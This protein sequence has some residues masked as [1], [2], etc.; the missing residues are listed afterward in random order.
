MKNIM[1]K[2]ELESVIMNAMD[3]L[4]HAID[5]AKKAAIRYDGNGEENLA[6]EVGYLRARINAAMYYLEK[7][8][9]M[10]NNALF[11]DEGPEYDSAGFSITAFEF[12][13]EQ[14]HHCDDLSCNCSI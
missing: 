12:E 4:E 5:D 14:S 9:L 1:T 6:F 2:N 8:G 7:A 3:H 11:T 10:S 13:E